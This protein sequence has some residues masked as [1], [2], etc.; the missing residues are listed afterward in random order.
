MYLADYREVCFSDVITRMEG[1]LFYK[2]TGIDISG[3]ELLV[4]QT[5]LTSP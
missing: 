2:V 3:F 4:F 1:G 5:S